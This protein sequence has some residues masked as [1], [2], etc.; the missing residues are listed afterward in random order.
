MG[1]RFVFGLTQTEAARKCGVTH[2]ILSQVERGMNQ[3]LPT[4]KKVAHGLGLE[5]EDLVIPDTPVGVE[6]GK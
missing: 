3:S 1:K 2:V 6:T 5:M 4:I